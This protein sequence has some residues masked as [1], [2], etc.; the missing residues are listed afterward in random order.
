MKEIPLCRPSITEAEISK[1]SEVLRSGWLAHGPCNQKFEEDFANFIG[2]PYALTMNSCTSAL[3]VALQINNI[4]GEVIVPS[5]TWVSTANV[6]KLSGGTPVFCEVDLSS[7]NVSASNIEPHINSRTEAVI[8]VHFGGQPC[9]MSEI[10]SL[11]DKHGL[12]LIEDSAET[13]GGTW[14][15]KQAGSFSHGCFSFF[16]TKNLTTGE[17]GMLTLHDEQLLRKAKRLIAHGIE[18]TTYDR[19]GSNRPWERSAY[20][21]GHNF[22]MSNP[23]AAIGIEQLKRLPWM[24]KRRQDIAKFY[25]NNIERTCPNIVIPKVVQGASHVYQMY[26]VLADE[27]SRNEIVLSL[28]EKGIGASV[29]FD[30]P[31]HMQPAYSSLEGKGIAL[32]ITEEIS[33]RIITLPIYPDMKLDDAEYVVNCLANIDTTKFDKYK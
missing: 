5:F 26:T 27:A 8:V 33:K 32:P 25:N 3:E 6:V 17:G 2:V 9:N 12:L 19:D 16:P 23:L 4:R 22:R 29:H 15:N 7:R 11:C 14:N 10:V 30:P 20:D 1:V 31:V 24:N 28:R 18:A 21:V 13:I